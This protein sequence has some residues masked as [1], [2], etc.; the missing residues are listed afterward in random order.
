MQTLICTKFNLKQ[1]V[2]F[3]KPLVQI[4]EFA[5]SH[6]TEKNKSYSALQ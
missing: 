4:E 3:T 1:A 2:N 6:T 5:S